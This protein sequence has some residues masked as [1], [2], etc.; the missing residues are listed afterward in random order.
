MLTKLL[1]LFN[2]I[3]TLVLLRQHCEK[4]S[5]WERRQRINGVSWRDGRWVGKRNCGGGMKGGGTVWTAEDSKDYG[6]SKN[7]VR[8]DAKNQTSGTETE[9]EKD[10]QKISRLGK[11]VWMIYSAE[12][13]LK[14]GIVKIHFIGNSKVCACVLAG[15]QVGCNYRGLN[16]DPTSCNA[17]IEAHIPRNHWREKE[18]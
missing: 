17:G 10:L 2:V 9:T 3:P 5:R 15:E 8:G 11:Q 18:L 6:G 13:L 12:H 16:A 7:I 1:L 14:H 4:L